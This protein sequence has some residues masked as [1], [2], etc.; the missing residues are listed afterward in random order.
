LAKKTYPNIPGMARLDAATGSLF[1]AKAVLGYSAHY[2]AAHDMRATTGFW[3]AFDL[4]HAAL[5][6]LCVG[7]VERSDTI[8][9]DV[10]R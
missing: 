8:N 7:W 4:Q 9:S 3:C 6:N 1:L 2:Q 5:H 10:E